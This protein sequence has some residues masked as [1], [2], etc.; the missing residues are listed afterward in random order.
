MTKLNLA[1]IHSM[2]KIYQE[3]TD[4]LMDKMQG[5][6]EVEDLEPGSQCYLK[7]PQSVVAKNQDQPSEYRNHQFE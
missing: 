6:K 7:R 1:R 3:R 2:V 4:Q 5:D